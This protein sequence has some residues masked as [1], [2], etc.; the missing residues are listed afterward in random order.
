MKLRSLGCLLTWFGFILTSIIATPAVAGVLPPGPGGA[1][2]GLTPQDVPA[3]FRYVLD[4]GTSTVSGSLGGSSFTNATWQFSAVGDPS[5]VTT[6]TI[7][8]D[9]VPY[10]FLPT[11]VHLRLQ[12]G[13]RV[14]TAT[15]TPV[16]AGEWGVISADI[17][18]EDGQQ[19]NSE[20][21]GMVLLDPQG[22]T[23]GAGLINSPGNGDSG[24][25][26][27]LSTLGFWNGG[28]PEIFSELN[29]ASTS[30]GQ[31]LITS[32]NAATGT[33]YF[34]VTTATIPEPS[35]LALTLLALAS[36]PLINHART[37]QQTA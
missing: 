4:G 8:P 24:L 34:E 19:I 26:N 37:R 13:S 17:L 12:E 22:T 9:N 2:G 5:L 28:N 31:L 30:R 20:A 35:T 11:T 1:P 32:F 36:I 21:A 27:P 6:G 29:L 18:F 23:P 16:Q 25:Y 10:Y 15:F 7:G 3:L 33:G 14:L